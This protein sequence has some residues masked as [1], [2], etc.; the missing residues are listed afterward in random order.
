MDLDRLTAEGDDWL[1]AE[2]RYALKAHGV[3]AQAQP[4]AFMIRVRTGG[5]IISS[6][7]AR[8]VASL[9]ERYG[10]GWIH[11]TTRQQIELHHVHTHDVTTVLA[12]VQRIGL[13]TNSAC[14]HTMRGVMSCPQAGI[15]LD[16][17]FDCYPDARMVSESILERT[18][19]L[20]YQ[21]PQRINILFGGCAEC[22]DHA[23]VNDAGFV[24]QVRD[25]GELG[26]ELLVGGS[27]GKS[28]PAL[29]IRAIDFLPRTEVLPAIHA[30]FDVFIDH[31]NFDQPGKARMKFLIAKLG[32]GDFLELFRAAFADA[33]RRPWPPPARVARPLSSPISEIL[34]CA[35][36][37][38]WSSG[39]RPQRV[40]GWAMVTVNVPLGD[41]Y[42]EELRVLA[43]VA[44][45]LGDQR[46]YL[47]RNQNVMLGWIPIEAVPAVRTALESV[48][49]FLEGADQARDVR[50]C[51][52]G[53]VCS[54]A[55]TPAQG[56]GA[57]LLDHPA[58]ARNS[59][60]RV[61]ISGCPNACAQHQIADLGFSGGM[62]TIARC[63]TLG[64][65]VWVGGDVRKDIIGRVVGRVAEADVPAIIEAIVGIWEALRERGETLADT[66]DRFGLDAFKTQIGAVFKGRWA[67]GPE[68]GLT[69][70]GPVEAEVDR[71]LPLIGGR[72]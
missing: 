39:V 14:G 46:I 13:T 43:D 7:E 24:S 57:R 16:E 62:V 30:L 49:L 66:V 10:R 1:S 18:P 61:G 41:L 19:E 21:M 44:D 60:L 63:Q 27:L 33:R 17:P 72:R 53:P 71:R 12:E 4:H 64:Y 69:S 56:L 8:E 28:S 59:G 31:G 68:P 58:L 51:T 50:A 65:Q 32:A 34:S 54:L 40:P 3:C 67:P 20:N 11:L 15:G 55:I 45:D 5:G 22:R 37:G 25:D 29:A 48:G 36:E 47:T 2:E 70:S 6:G 38:G 52:G 26:Y 9:A 23:K 35:P 42:A